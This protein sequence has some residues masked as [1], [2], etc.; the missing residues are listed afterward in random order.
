MTPTLH[1]GQPVL[2]VGAP[3]GQGQAVMVML[4]GRGA[5]PHDVL[6]LVPACRATG[7][8]YLAPTAANNTWYPYRFIADFA[9]N[10]PWLSSALAVVADP[11]SQVGKLGIPRDRIMLLGF[12]QGACLA[13]EFAVRNANRY[14]GVVMLSGGLIGPPGTKWEYPGSLAGTPAFLGCSDVDPHIPVARVEESAQV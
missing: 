6:N 9:S 5:S 3:I 2:T 8:T 4:H 1:A 11:G 14:G 12:S 7:F 10:E 13:G